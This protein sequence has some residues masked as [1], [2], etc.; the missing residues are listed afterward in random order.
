MRKRQQSSGKQQPTYTRTR[1][2]SISTP[3]GFLRFQ[4]DQEKKRRHTVCQ[5]TTIRSPFISP[6]LSS[7]TCPSCRLDA[8]DITHW[9]WECPAGDAIRQQVFGN[10]KRSLEWLATRPGDVVKYT[11]KTLVN[12]EASKYDQVSPTFHFFEFLLY[13]KTLFG[14]HVQK[15]VK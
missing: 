2:A 14:R 8:Q 13:R 7:S 10:H 15:I 4:T 6:L 5:I 9:L 11:R 12:L 1:P 3:K